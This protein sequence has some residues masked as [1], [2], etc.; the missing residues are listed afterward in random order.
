MSD[1]LM[2]TE[3]KR[4][5]LTSADTK[6]IGTDYQFFYFINELLKLKKGQQLGYEEKLYRWICEFNYK[7]AKRR[8]IYYG[9]PSYEAMKDYERKEV[10]LGGCLITDNDPDYGCLCCNHRWSV[11]DFKVEDIMKFRLNILMGEK[12]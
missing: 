3:R 10:I 7:R 2:K 12:V 5:D 8:S 9:M 1:I 4:Y 11:K 6:I